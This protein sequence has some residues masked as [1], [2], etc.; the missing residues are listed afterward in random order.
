MPLNVE[1]LRVLS[2]SKK[3]DLDNSIQR[4][5]D[6]FE[7]DN[8]GWEV[9]LRVNKNKIDCKFFIDLSQCDLCLDR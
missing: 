4:I 5:I 2:N 7:S 1:S 3:N 8:K 6:E 9:L